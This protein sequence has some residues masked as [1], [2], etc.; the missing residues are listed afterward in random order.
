MS[1][2]CAACD[3]PRMI[4]AIHADNDPPQSLISI[5][6]VAVAIAVGAALWFGVGAIAILLAMIWMCG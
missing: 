6:D 4:C 5:A 2:K 3:N 1:D